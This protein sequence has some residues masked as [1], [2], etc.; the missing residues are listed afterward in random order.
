MDNIK[1]I[2]KPTA[3]ARYGT[4]LLNAAK[5]IGTQTAVGAVK[6]AS[7]VDRLADSAE[8]EEFENSDILS[9]DGMES[10]YP[11]SAGGAVRNV[12]ILRNQANDVQIV[13]YDVKIRVNRRNTII[14][15][16]LA[17]RTGS[18]KEYIQ[19]QDYDISVSGSLISDHRIKFPLAELRAVV[20][21]LHKAETFTLANVYLES[22]GISKVVLKSADYDQ[23]SQQF[24]N[25][26]PFS[27]NFVSDEDYE[28][29]LTET[30]PNL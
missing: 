24:V 29:E 8:V 5:Y 19:A 9:I 16:P 6:T 4:N 20:E 26:L 21:L 18:V 14:E 11:T 17:G 25:V 27:F 2:Y 15:T 3:A 7:Y 22:F 28:L 12:L 13:F 10:P 23:Q 1:I 30:D